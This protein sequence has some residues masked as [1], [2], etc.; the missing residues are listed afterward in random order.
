MEVYY[1]LWPIREV[2][3]GEKLVDYV[4]K[5]EDGVIVSNGSAKELTRR[6]GT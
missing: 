6:E 4:G 5:V 1:I 2:P 3:Y